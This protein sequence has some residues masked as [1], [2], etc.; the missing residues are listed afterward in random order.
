MNQIHF[1]E[2]P[3]G[4]GKSTYAKALAK[5]DGFTHIALD[6][7]FVR[8]YSPDRPARN[9]V[10]WYVE[11]KDRLIALILSYARTV[12]ATNSIA[13]ELGLIQ[14]GPRLALLRQ[15]QE[16]GIPFCVHVLDAPKSVR[17]ERVQRR[18]TEQGETFSMVVP[19]E[20]FEVASSLWESPDEFEQ[21]EFEFVFP[22]TASR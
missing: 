8:L 1:I 17:R 22:A 21:E 5:T 15:L 13:L 2:G 9:F 16:E 3:V 4:A 14:Q 11:R 20:I 7:W 10:P 6:E 12:L 19:D 18:N